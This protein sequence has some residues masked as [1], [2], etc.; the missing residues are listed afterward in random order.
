MTYPRLAGSFAAGPRQ[1]A[2]GFR[3]LACHC[4][5]AAGAVWGVVVVEDAFAAVRIKFLLVSKNK[6][7]LVGLGGV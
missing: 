7:Y 1:A 5:P 3:Q 6:I 4:L 2:E